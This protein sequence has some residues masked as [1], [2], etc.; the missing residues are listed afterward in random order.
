LDRGHDISISPAGT[1]AFVTGFELDDGNDG[2]VRSVTIA[3]D[4]AGSQAGEARWVTRHHAS[5]GNYGSWHNAV[6]EDGTRIFVSSTVRDVN[7][8]LSDERMLTHAY[9]ATTGKLLWTSELGG[10]D[11]GFVPGHTGTDRAWKGAVSVS[12][13]NDLVYVT[14][15]H[16]EGGTCT[17][18]YALVTVAYDQTT[19]EERWVQFHE[20]FGP[21][22]TVSH[23]K[24]VSAATSPDGSV[25][26]V[27]GA[28]CW[29]PEDRGTSDQTTLA[30]AANTGE[31]LGVARHQYSEPGLND[32]LQILVSPEGGSI[33]TVSDV[34]PTWP[35]PTYLGISTYSPPISLSANAFRSRRDWL[36]DLT[37]IGSGDDEVEILRD[38]TLI[39]E[40]DDTNT[41]TDELDRP[42][43]GST[44]TYKVCR[45]TVSTCSNEVAVEIGNRTRAG[46]P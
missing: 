5:T 14:G 36:V 13:D 15:H 25:L 33:Y 2:H 23:P 27:A 45:T 18:R 37:W 8:A 21:P 35:Q 43:K 6:S 39:A 44:F 40:I 41:Y 38:G 12:P 19:G 7:A 10:A 1:L 34:L 29:T 42:K 22:G 3:Y 11:H 9:D 26:Y 32:G 30:Y 17:G 24:A 31:L 16:C 28:C 4:L 20:S 46:V